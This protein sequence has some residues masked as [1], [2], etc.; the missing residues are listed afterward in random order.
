[1]VI[2]GYMSVNRSSSVVNDGTSVYV[3][4]GCDWRLCYVMS[5]WRQS[6]CV[7]SQSD[8]FC[9]I[10]FL[11]LYKK[12]KYDRIKRP[13]GD[14]KTIVITKDPCTVFWSACVRLSYA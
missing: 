4:I 14:R 9:I 3:V 12:D 5:L 6:G 13:N 8:V 11:L 7:I 1:M 10:N 2:N